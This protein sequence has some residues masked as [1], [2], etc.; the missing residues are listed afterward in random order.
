MGDPDDGNLLGID[1]VV[2]DVIGDRQTPKPKRDFVASA[3][4]IHECTEFLQSFGNSLSIDVT[5]TLTPHSERVADDRPKI[6]LGAW[7]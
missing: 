5:L 1:P 2:D 4:E 3:T 7:Q 6:A